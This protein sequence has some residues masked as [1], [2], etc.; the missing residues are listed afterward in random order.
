MKK[1]FDLSKQYATDFLNQKKAVEEVEDININTNRFADITSEK[2]KIVAKH[3]SNFVY[4]ALPYNNGFYIH[5]S[6]EH[7]QR[8]FL[9]FL[10]QK[11][12]FNYQQKNNCEVV[13]F[14]FD[15]LLWLIKYYKIDLIVTIMDKRPINFSPDNLYS[16]AN[17]NSQNI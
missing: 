8:E 14:K 16:F 10:S 6:T 5:N 9:V 17:E 2:V 4:A 3:L 11:E 15:D 12:L 7:N 13:Y 1:I